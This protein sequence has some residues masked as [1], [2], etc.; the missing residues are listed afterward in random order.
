MSTQSSG[1]SGILTA[2][3]TLN[4]ALV[5]SRL[6]LAAL[7]ARYKAGSYS[8]HPEE[9]LEAIEGVEWKIRDSI[10]G[11]PKPK[12]AKVPA[13]VEA[14]TEPRGR[15]AAEQ[16]EYDE[17]TARCHKNGGPF[18]PGLE[19]AERRLAY[20]QDL[21]RHG[22]FMGHPE[23]LMEDIETEQRHVRRLKAEKLTEAF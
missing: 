10:Q 4:P 13:P 21:Y 5:P 19:A 6:R 20:M 17:L 8:G 2:L 9:M 12:A 7:R 18:E 22:G 15:T 11:K 14:A 23:D 1:P 16:R 3:R